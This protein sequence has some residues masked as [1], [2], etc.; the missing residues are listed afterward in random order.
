MRRV[1]NAASTSS[2][3]LNRNQAQDDLGSYGLVSGR[4]HHVCYICGVP[5]PSSVLSPP[6]RMI[7]TNPLELCCFFLVW[8]IY[9]YL[10]FEMLRCHHRRAM[11]I[12]L[13]FGPRIG[14]P[15]QYQH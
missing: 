6:N 11:V 1:E 13:L 14:V 8:C 7:E 10:P 2:L 12:G 5:R 4:V 15:V 9:M 3:A